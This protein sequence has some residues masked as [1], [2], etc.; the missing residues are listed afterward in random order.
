MWGSA[1]INDCM[2]YVEDDKPHELIY[3]FLCVCVV[4]HAL[5]SISQ[6][7]YHLNWKSMAICGNFTLL[8]DN[9][10]SA[11]IAPKFCTGHISDVAEWAEIRSGCWCY[12]VYE[13]YPQTSDIKLT[14]V[15]NQIVDRWDVVG[16]SPVGAA[17]ITSAFST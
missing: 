4:V 5:Q 3:F 11:L 17:P 2:N 14:L 8:S 7:L 9:M 12:T 10:I 13:M 16:A 15:I 6:K 1:V